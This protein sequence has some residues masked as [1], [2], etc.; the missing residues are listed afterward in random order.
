VVFSKFAHYAGS[1]DVGS[2]RPVYAQ[3][4]YQYIADDQ[5]AAIALQTGALDFG[6]V[7]LTQVSTVQGQ[8]G[9]TMYKRVT[10]NIYWLGLNVTDPDLSDIRVRQAIRYAVD[11]P[12]ILTAA[13]NNLWAPAYA[14]V[15]PGVPIGYWKDAPRYKRNVSQAKDL[16]KRAGKQNLAIN[17]TIG[18]GDPSAKSIAEVVKSSLGEAG[19][20]VNIQLID[21]STEYAE[22]FAK[23]LQMFEESSLG[24]QDPNFVM[25][26]WQC[27]Q[28]GQWNWNEW[29][30]PQYDQL[31]KKAAATLDTATRDGQYIELQRLIDNAAHT[32]Y[33]GYPTYYFAGKNSIDAVVSPS[34]RVLAWAFHPA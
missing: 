29:C 23:K 1:S 27:S 10:P 16:L 21:S 15:G 7:G 34:G 33:T 3:A 17:F 22:G 8:S 18:N 5:A 30:S 19:I 4:V 32:I 28:R 24:F 2:A 26:W 25:Q 31:Y 20:N 12:G 13:Y 14:A 11:V 6:D 9:L